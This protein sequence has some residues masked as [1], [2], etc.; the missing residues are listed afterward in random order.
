MNIIVYFCHMKIEEAIVFCLAT[1]NRGMRS[2]QIADKE[3]VL[4]DI[5]DGDRRITD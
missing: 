3:Q 1:S 2:E 4:S 5:Y